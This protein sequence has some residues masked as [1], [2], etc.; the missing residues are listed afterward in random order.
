MLCRQGNDWSFAL[1]MIDGAFSRGNHVIGEKAKPLAHRR[2]LELVG[3]VT[4][5]ILGSCSFSGRKREEFWLFLQ[6][7]NRMDMGTFVKLNRFAF[8][9]LGNGGQTEVTCLI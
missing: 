9:K 2:L 7:K 6:K 5:H 4:G 8:L 1:D 3:Y